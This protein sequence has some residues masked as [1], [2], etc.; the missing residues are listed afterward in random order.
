MHI[1][2]IDDYVCELIASEDYKAVH[3][4]VIN[5]YNNIV[6]IVEANLGNAE[7]L[8]AKEEMRRLSGS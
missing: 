2:L 8:E 1:S 6:E 7:Q 5:G 3:D 4:L